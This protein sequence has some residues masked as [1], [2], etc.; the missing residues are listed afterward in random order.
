M[1]KKQSEENQDSQRQSRKEVLLARRH[2]RQTRQVRIIIAVVVGI[3]LLVL[4]VAIVNEYF[5]VPNRVVASVRGDDITLEAW[6]QRVRYQRAQFII[7][8]EDQLETFGDVGMVQQFNGQQMQ[9]LQEGEELGRLVLEA[10]VDERIVRQEAERRGISVTEEE[11]DEFIA[12]SFSYFGGE[13]PTPLPTPTETIMPTPSLTPIPT[14]VITDV[15]PTLTPFPT[16]TLGPT[17][18]PLPTATPVSETSF[19]EQLT[20]QIER[21]RQMG[22][23]EE[24]YRATVAAQLYT[25]KLADA[26]AEEEE[27]QTEDDHVSTYVLSFGS[28]EEAEEALAEIEASDYLAV[29]NTIRSMP[30]DPEVEQPPQASEVLWRTQDQFESSFSTEIAGALFST[31]VDTPTGILVVA[32]QTEEQPDR[33]YIFMPSGNE[34]RPL[35]EGTIDSLKNQLVADLVDQIRSAETIDIGQFWRT[36]VPRQPILDA[37]F[38]VPPT[39]AP[40]Q[41]IVT[42]TPAGET[43]EDDGQ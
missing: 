15:L 31:E 30:P 2:S 22:V 19:N 16:P 11:I 26:L 13:S 32:G 29:W 8:M 35:T 43:E 39:V 24:E 10:M 18:T 7:N 41:P 21:F 17:R 1:A 33:Y 4:G 36:R 34:I 14:E 42:T 3:I 5:I 12:E 25:Q 38:L 27:L 9:L 40:T 20:S 37:K 28:Q 6:Q 23:S